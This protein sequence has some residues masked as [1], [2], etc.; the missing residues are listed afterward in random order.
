MPQVYF[1]FYSYCDSHLTLFGFSLL[2]QLGRVGI[3][4][5]SKD[6]TGAPF[7][8]SMS[9]L[10]TGAD[11]AYVLTAEEAAPALKTYSP[12]LMV[13]YNFWDDHVLAVQY[14]YS[15][16]PHQMLHTPVGVLALQVP[17]AIA[18]TVP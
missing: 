8:A 9:S 3:F 13:R 5:G 4:G 2:R 7:F 16:H 6:Y 10:R 1:L 17:T 12:E 11:L 18:D 14:N 15:G